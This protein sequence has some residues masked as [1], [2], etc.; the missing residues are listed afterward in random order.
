MARRHKLTASDFIG[1]GGAHNIAD[2]KQRLRERDARMARDT[3]TEVQK[4][5]GE[6]EPSRSAL[7]QIGLRPATPKRASGVRCDL[8]TKR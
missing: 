5:L 7:A 3:R 4:M 6:P 8:W 2:G 1:L